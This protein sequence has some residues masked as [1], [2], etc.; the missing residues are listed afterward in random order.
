[1]GTIADI[2][3]QSLGEKN[4]KGYAKGLKDSSEKRDSSIEK[5][6][7]GKPNANTTPSRFVRYPR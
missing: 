7:K 5:D 3:Y 1:M 6:K 4:D 2:S